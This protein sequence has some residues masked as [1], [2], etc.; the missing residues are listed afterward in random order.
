M[1]ADVGSLRRVILEQPERYPPQRVNSIS[2]FL[3]RHLQ[4]S[5]AAKPNSPPYKPGKLKRALRLDRVFVALYVVFILCLTL[6]FAGST[7]T[8]FGRAVDFYHFV[9][10]A[11]SVLL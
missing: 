11:W 1:L 8:L 6:V 7:A 2:Y 5:A 4:A 9:E 3:E 10:Q